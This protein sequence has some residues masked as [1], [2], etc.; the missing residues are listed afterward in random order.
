[1]FKKIIQWFRNHI[2][3]RIIRTDLVKGK[4]GKWHTK[5]IK[6]YYIKK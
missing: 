5:H 6:R 1:M 3:Y 2:D 4:D